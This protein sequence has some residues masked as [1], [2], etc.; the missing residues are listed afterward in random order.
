M[1]WKIIYP[2]WRKLERQ[3]HFDLPPHGPVVFAAAIPPEVD[4]EMV[5]TNVDDL[6]FDNSPD[7]VCLSVMLTAQIPHA[8]D[9]AAEYRERG[10]PVLAGGI[11]VMLHFEQIRSSFDSVFLGEAEGRMEQ[12][13][14]DL[15]RGELKPVYNYLHDFPKMDL[16]GTARRNLLNRQAYTYREVQM[17]DLVH[18]SRGCRFKCFPCC[19]G[20]LGGSIFRPRPLDLVVKEIESIDNDRLFLVDN[21]LAQDYHWEEELFEALIPLGKIWVSHPI[22]EDDHLLDLAYQAGCWYVY[23]AVFDTSN[24]IRSRIQRYHD[25]GIKV[26]ATVILGTDDHDVDSI[27]KLVDFLL[28]ID[29]DLAEFTI[30]TPFAFSPIRAKLEKEGRILSH[31]FEEYTCDRVVFQPRKMTPDQLQEMFYYAWDTFYAS[32]SQ[33]LKMGKLFINALKRQAERGRKS[34]ILRKREKIES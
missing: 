5:D 17:V 32:E 2:K 16:I 24:K 25:H 28:E 4:I 14:D 31:R 7:L 15:E 3:T 6:I 33:E 26:E 10:I 18:A 1:K 23:Q 8:L 20:Y 21:S 12:V 19:T 9:I 22:E 27:K 29:L 11:A 30:L 13:A 34:S